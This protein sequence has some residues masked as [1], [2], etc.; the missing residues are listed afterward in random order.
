MS[1][2]P[3]PSKLSGILVALIPTGFGIWMLAAPHLMDGAEPHG[4]RVLFK[5]LLAWIW[6][7][8]GGIVLLL[9]G[10]LLLW[11]AFQPE[12]PDAGDGTK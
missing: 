4:R 3:R 5:K 7:Y 12:R 8:P 1:T 11:A 9:L 2:E 6:G 10:L